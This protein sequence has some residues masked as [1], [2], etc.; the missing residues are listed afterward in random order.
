MDKL[1]L[2]DEEWKKKL[3]PEQYAVLRGKGTEAP[4]SGEHVHNTDEG[5][6]TCM[7]CDAPLFD[8]ETKIDDSNNQTP[9]LAGWPA[10]EKA[11]EGAIEYIED[12]SHGMHRTEAV[13][14]RCGSH[15]GHLFPDDTTSTGQHFCINS[16]SLDHKEK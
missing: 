7:A 2:S 16:V 1:N 9:G 14:A 6:F 10:F 13:C 4:F 3:T 12:D 11:I 15:L 8:S 5:V